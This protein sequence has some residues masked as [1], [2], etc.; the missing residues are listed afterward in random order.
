MK[1][2]I[3]F[4]WRTD[5]SPGVGMLTL[6]D[7][8]NKVLILAHS[9]GYNVT[10]ENKPSRPLAMGNH[11]PHVEVYPLRKCE[12]PTKHDLYTDA[13]PDRPDVICDSMGRVTLALC[14]RCGKA[15][16]ELDAPCA[17]KEQTK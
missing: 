10:I 7:K 2:S 9:L 16:A 6:V 5:E 14:K 13:D 11:A 8:I 4:T 12:P 3:D 1:P 17:P 15:E